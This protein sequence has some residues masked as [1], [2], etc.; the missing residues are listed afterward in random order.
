MQKIFNIIIFC[1]AVLIAVSFFM[2]WLEGEGSLLKPLDDSTKSLQKKD[3]TG[4]AKGSITLSKRIT[5]NITQ[6]ITK[7]KL[8]QTLKGHQIPQAATKKPISVVY[9]LYLVPVLPFFCWWFS[10]LGN[11]R[12]FF[13]LIA[14]FI[15]LGVFAVF[16]LQIDAL[17]HE[18][19][20][21]KI[22]SCCWLPITIKLFLA[23]GVLAVF[24]FLLPRKPRPSPDK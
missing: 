16:I 3:I 15:A 18:G 6:A 17:N 10:V 24:K 22:R 20:F 21:I 1:L 12:R 14:A 5:D 23:I 7:K 19:L 2:P 8:K 9:L 11:R 4:L 13:D